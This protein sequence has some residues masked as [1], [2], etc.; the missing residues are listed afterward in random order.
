MQEDRRFLASAPRHGSR[1]AGAVSLS[2]SQASPVEAWIAAAALVAIVATG[3]FGT[4]AAG[5]FIAAAMLLIALRPLTSLRDL[6][7]FWPLLLLPLLAMASTL[8]SDAPERTLRAALQLLLTAIAAIMVCRRLEA[9]R[10]ILALFAGC[11]VLAAAALPYVPASLAYGTPLVGPFG[12]KNAMGFSAH[13]LVALA[14]AVVVDRDQPRLARLV[15]LVALP[16][17]ALLLYL[18]S[19]AGAAVSMGITVLIFPALVLLSWLPP[20]G[21][22]VIFLL[23]ILATTVGM[24][25]FNDIVA[26]AADFR[27]NVLHKD[28]TLTG[29][30]YLWDYADH[31]NRERPWLG[32]GYYAFWRQ[33]NLDA[34]GLW[35]WG[36]IASRTGF[37][38]HNAF[39]EMQVDLGWLG[40]GLLVAMC[41]GITAVGAYRQFTRPTIPMAFF[42]AFLAVSLSRAL[43]E[44]NLVAPF[45]GVMMLTFATAVYAVAPTTVR[46]RKHSATAGQPDAGGRRGALPTRPDRSGRQGA[47]P[48]RAPARAYNS[49]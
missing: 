47:S 36:G 33:G 1:A 38:F 48:A 8:W 23:L 44:T 45:S 41:A 25:F 42:L 37:N 49:R 30:T 26:A 39:V 28:A 15:A 6:L 22:L 20:R 7:R 40:L 46:R 10:A 2:G 31:L 34:E 18:S 17:G 35:R 14:L 13:L 3:I 29:R 21:R 24:I 11:V 19:S 27:Q 9:D 32:G 16:T 4:V 5:L 12:S 43:T